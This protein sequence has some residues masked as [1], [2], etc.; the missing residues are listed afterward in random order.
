M[1][2]TTRTCARMCRLGVSLTLLPILGVKSPENPN[3]WG[4]IRRFQAKRAKPELP[5]LGLFW[6]RM[7]M[8]ARHLWLDQTY[9]T[10]HMA[11][12]ESGFKLSP[13][14]HT[15]YTYHTYGC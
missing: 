12:S 7:G 5:I 9:L 2:Q 13:P 4:V 3:F 11:G 15:Y 10:W 6:C 14:D 1:A 8:R